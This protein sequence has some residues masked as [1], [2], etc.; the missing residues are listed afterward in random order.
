MMLRLSSNVVRNALGQF[1]IVDFSD[2]EPGHKCPGHKKCKAL[3]FV[4]R[5]SCQLSKYLVLI[6]CLGHWP[7]Y[8]ADMLAAGVLCTQ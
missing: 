3:E 2:A 8:D 7:V 1:R 5:F 6:D 4:R